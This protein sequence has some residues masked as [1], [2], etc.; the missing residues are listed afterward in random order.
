MAVPAGAAHRQGEPGG[1]PLAGRGGRVQAEQ[2][3]GGGPALGG[4]E[5]QAQ[6]EL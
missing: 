4:Q 2:P 6:H 1:D 3:G 5:E